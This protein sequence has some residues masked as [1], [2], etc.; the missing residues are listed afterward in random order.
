MVDPGCIDL[1]VTGELTGELGT[2][3]LQIVSF[4]SVLK[5]AGRVSGLDGFESHPRRLT[6]LQSLGRA[7]PLRRHLVLRRI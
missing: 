3:A 5:T 1:R 7:R 2:K 6:V 4:S